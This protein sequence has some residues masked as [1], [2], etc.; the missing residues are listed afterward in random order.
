MKESGAYMLRAGL[1]QALLLSNA[2][3]LYITVPNTNFSQSPRRLRRRP[4]AARL[5]RYGFESN[6][7]HGCFSVVSVMCCQVEICATG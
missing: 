2:S 7:R 4:A 5:L 6:Q 1:T 3:L